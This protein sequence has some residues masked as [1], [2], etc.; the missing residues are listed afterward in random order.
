MTTLAKIIAA[1]SEDNIKVIKENNVVT[2]DIA[3]I[4]A[5]VVEEFVKIAIHC[6][7]NGPVGVNHPATFPHRKDA[8]QIN[9]LWPQMTS[10]PWKQF[11]L[12]VAGELMSKHQESIKGA[13]TLKF[14]GVLWP[15]NDNLFVPKPKTEKSQ[16]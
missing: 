4:P 16:N 15:L 14:G 11:C 10:S 1:V 5:D 9:R 13:Y 2:L 3:K 6:C 12:I 7:M 8:V